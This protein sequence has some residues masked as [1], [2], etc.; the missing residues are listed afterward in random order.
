MNCL[1]DNGCLNYTSKINNYL[2]LISNCIQ[3]M[4]NQN[5]ILDMNVSDVYEMITM[6][7]IMVI[8]ILIV[9]ILICID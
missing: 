1:I 4:C 2:I 3:P 7:I 9:K 5:I 6:C 8:N